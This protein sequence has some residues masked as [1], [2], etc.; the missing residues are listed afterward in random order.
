V[1][2]GSRAGTIDNKEFA[3]V[4]CVR[5]SGQPLS[6]LLDNACCKLRLPA[7]STIFYVLI[8]EPGTERSTLHLLHGKMQLLSRRLPSADPESKTSE[9]KM[10]VRP[11]VLFMWLKGPS[12]PPPFNLFAMEAIE[13]EIRLVTDK[14][15]TRMLHSVELLHSVEGWLACLEEESS[16]LRYTVGAT[17]PLQDTVTRACTAAGLPPEQAK[18]MGLKVIDPAAESASKSPNFVDLPSGSSSTKRSSCGHAAF[19]A[20]NGADL[21]KLH[22]SRP[23]Y[24]QLYLVPSSW[25]GS[26]Q[27]VYNSCLTI[28]A[29]AR[30]AAKAS[31]ARAVA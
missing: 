25:Y 10:G 11:G 23:T 7:E 31:A 20:T 5:A 18:L 8:A 30:A 4:R 17:L 26:L 29:A 27:E 21:E 24:Q 1:H 9:L 12:A 6:A 28:A 22:P 3:N 13:I 15:R 14:V 19:D 2:L 16:K